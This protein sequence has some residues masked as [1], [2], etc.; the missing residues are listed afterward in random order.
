MAASAAVTVCTG[1][2]VGLFLNAYA[3]LARTAFRERTVAYAQAFAANAESWLARGQ[4]DVVET[5]ARFLVAGSV[6]SVEVVGPNGVVLRE[7]SD[8]S[9]TS[10]EGPGSTAVVRRKQ[11]GVR[12]LDVVIPMTLA[13]GR[14]RMAVDVSS[15]ELAIHQAVLLGIGGAVL[16]DAGVLGL[17]AWALRGRRRSA[18]GAPATVA[19]DEG[20]I[21]VGDLVI[22]PS[23]CTA[24]FAG[25]P[26]R[27]TPKQFA[28]LG[29]LA[30]EPGRVFSEVEI[31]AA[32]WP[33]SPY[34]DARD[35]KQYIYLLRRRLSDVR[36]DGRD[37]IVTVPG[38]GYRLND[39]R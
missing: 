5:L 17:L 23:R 4:D 20:E 9:A 14:V 27:L 32:A 31:L 13:D 29:V 15:S 25:R 2:A 11:G 24:S 6:L 28:L 16:F 39:G 22:V 26:L 19:A 8:L 10:S 33:D 34:A 38:F 21:A 12:Y 7:G 3:S 18:N 35:I 36:S 1:L 37:V 30:S